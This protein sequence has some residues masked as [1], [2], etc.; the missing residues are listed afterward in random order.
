[1]ILLRLF[2]SG[3][4]YTTP[5]R[6]RRALRK[7]ELGD[8]EVILLAGELK[9]LVPEIHIDEKN[10]MIAQSI[11]ASRLLP[12][13]DRLLEIYDQAI[14]RLKALDAGLGSES[15]DLEYSADD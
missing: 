10:P 4:V 2:K 15:E 3:R 14:E 8:E 13:I 7:T 1:L 5:L 11:Q 6:L 9:K 12:N